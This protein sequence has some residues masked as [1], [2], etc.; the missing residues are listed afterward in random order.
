MRERFKSHLSTICCS[1]C[2]KKKLVCFA[3]STS[4]SFLLGLDIEQ[5][6]LVLGHFLLY[7]FIKRPWGPL[8]WISHVLGRQFKYWELQQT[9]LTLWMMN[10]ESPFFFLKKRSSC[11]IL[12]YLFLL[13]ILIDRMKRGATYNSVTW[14]PVL[15]SKDPCRIYILISTEYMDTYE[16][17]WSHFLRLEESWTLSK[18]TDLISSNNKFDY[19]IW[20]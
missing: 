11:D 3:I 4:D 20:Y 9:K 13:M 5:W 1:E 10:L 18:M 6:F 17:L 15:S 12:F 16:V 8:D 7:N 19:L 14:T 2:K